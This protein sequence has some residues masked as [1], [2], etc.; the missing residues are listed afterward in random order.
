METDSRLYLDA[1]IPLING[2]KYWEQ[3]IVANETRKQSD[4]FG[5]LF[6]VMALNIAGQ[7]IVGVLMELDK[8]NVLTEQMNNKYFQSVDFTDSNIIVILSNDEHDTVVFTTSGVFINGHL[9]D[10]NTSFKLERRQRVEIKLSADA[11]GFVKDGGG[12]F[13]VLND[14]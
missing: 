12:V 6:G 8:Y 3:L 5:S 1:Q 7:I 14:N 13:F 10:E 11:S 4:P 9:V 2:E